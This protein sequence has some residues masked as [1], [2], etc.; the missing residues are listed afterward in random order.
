VGLTPDLAR[1]LERTGELVRL[2]EHIVFPSEV[3]QDIVATVVALITERGP[4]TVADVRDAIGTS[5]KY[6]VP[7]LEHL[8]ATGIT[9][10]RDD[11]RIL[12]PRGRDIANA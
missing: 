8:D 2:D 9:A 6:A 7:I 11:A 4:V 5:R 12:G 3:I 10:R 1:A